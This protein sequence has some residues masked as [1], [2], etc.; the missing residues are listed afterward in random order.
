MKHIAVNLSF[1]DL[2]TP[3][4]TSGNAY[5]WGTLLFYLKPYSL[6]YMKNR[7]QQFKIIFGTMF[8][9]F[10]LSGYAAGY[11]GLTTVRRMPPRVPGKSASMIRKGEFHFIKSQKIF[12]KDYMLLT[13]GESRRLLRVTMHAIRLVF[14]KY[15][16]L[17]V[18]ELFIRLNIQIN[19]CLS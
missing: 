2:F 3:S 4:H 7:L 12:V 5:L 16:M 8:L 14:E 18:K 1:F 11:K 17:S 15:Q 6:C 19:L 13:Y 10:T 9:L